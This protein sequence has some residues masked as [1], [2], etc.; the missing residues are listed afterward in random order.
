MQRVI[1][2]ADDFGIS[3]NVN[4]AICECFDRYMVTSTTLMVNM[5]FADEAVKL[6]KQNGFET[7]VG[8]H[9]N[10]T[11]GFPLTD[12]IKK[13]SC[14]CGKD[15]SF[16]AAF[17]KNTATRL[18]LNKEETKALSTEIEAQLHKYLNYGLPDRHLDSHHHV[19]TNASVYKPLE[20]LL[21]KYGI[22]SIRLTRNIYDRISLLKALYKKRYNL[23]LRRTGI[24]T[25]DY[26]GSYTDLRNCHEK[27]PD[28]SLTEIMVHPMYGEDGVLYDTSIP[29]EE[30]KQFFTSTGASLELFSIS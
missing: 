15:G 23:R 1:I 22:R 6:A 3:Q 29:M 16:N 25:T 19:H 13:Y 24:F 14:F 9:L 20:P 30:E 11:S 27:I 7:R 12:G 10:L 8:L 28:N 21:K 18:Y 17:Q 26:F 4:S 2:N 5:P